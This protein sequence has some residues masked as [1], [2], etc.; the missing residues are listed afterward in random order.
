MHSNIVLHQMK[1]PYALQHSTASTK[2]PYVLQ[3]STAST[4]T[5]YV[6]THRMSRKERI[7][8]ET[9]ITSGYGYLSSESA[10]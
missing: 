4:R 5:P 7:Y 3:D 1:M 6:L 2:T 8:P 9:S 10:G